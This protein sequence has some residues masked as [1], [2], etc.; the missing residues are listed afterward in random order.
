MRCLLEQ[1]TCI[2]I[3]LLQITWEIYEIKVRDFIPA[4]LGG[5]SFKP[6]IQ[7]NHKYTVK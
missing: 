4:V 7:N 2:Q 6:I 1:V 3:G 5:D